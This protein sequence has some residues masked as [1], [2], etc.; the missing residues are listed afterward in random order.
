ME[1]RGSVADNS[2]GDQAVKDIGDALK[3]G[4]ERRAVSKYV[5]DKEAAVKKTVESGK[6]SVK[7][8]YDRADKFLTEKE[9]KYLGGK[10]AP[11]TT[12]RAAYKR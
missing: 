3:L 6:S 7:Q 12:K 8:A 2:V 1:G 9:E 4:P 11:K 5:D 10:P